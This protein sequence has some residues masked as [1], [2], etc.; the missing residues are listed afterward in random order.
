MFPEIAFKVT[1]EDWNYN[2]FVPPPE[3]Y[4]SISPCYSGPYGHL[5]RWCYFYYFEERCGVI[6]LLPQMFEYFNLTFCTDTYTASFFSEAALIF[7]CVN[8]VLP[9]EQNI[10]SKSFILS[11]TGSSNEEITWE[12][13]IKEA[14]SKSTFANTFTSIIFYT[15]F[16]L[17]WTLFPSFFPP[18]NSY[19]SFRYH[20]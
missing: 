15:L 9:S 6:Y 13:E 1:S 10:W 19:S 16:S 8:H 12:K 20:L 11:A 7:I 2:Y 5:E 18:P 14:F 17:P 3:L 4:E